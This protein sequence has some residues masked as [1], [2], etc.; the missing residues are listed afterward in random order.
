MNMEPVRFGVIGCGLMGREFASVSMRWLHLA[1]EL[2][3]PVIVAACDLSPKNLDW[4]RQVPD[5]KYFYSDYHELLAN[6][7]VEAVYCAVPHH[8]HAQVYGDVIRAGKHLI[9]ENLSAWTLRPAR[10]WRPPW[11]VA[12]RYLCGAPANFHSIPPYSRW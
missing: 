10:R 9:G 1:C 7:E 6:P 12:P 5:T 2:P 8:L 4:F 3:R 11:P